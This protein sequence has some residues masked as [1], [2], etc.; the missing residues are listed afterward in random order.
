VRAL[1]DRLVAAQRPIRILD[2]IKWDDE[3]AGTFFRSGCRELPPVTRDYYSNRSL[4]FEPEDKLQELGGIERDIRKQL[5]E[6]DALAQILLRMSWEYRDAVRMLMHRGTK[7]FVDISRQLYGSASE[8]V[9]AVR[10]EQFGRLAA[11]LLHGSRKEFS[12][13]PEDTCDSQR[14]VDL[15]AARLTK[16]FRNEATVRVRLADGIASEAAAGS[17]YIKI[18]RGAQFTEQEVRLVE[19]HEGWVHFGTT[20]NGLA[21]PVCTFLSKGP[22]A[23]TVTQ[24]GLAVITEILSR[25]SHP[26]RIRRLVHRARGVAMAAAGADFLE[27]YRFFVEKGCDAHESY[28]CAARVFRGSLPAG[29]GPF[30]KD[31]SYSKGFGLIYD[32]TRMVSASKLISQLP[33]LFCG[34]TNIA[35]LAVLEQLVEQGIIVPPRFVPSVFTDPCA[36]STCIRRIKSLPVNQEPT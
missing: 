30:S 19:V 35:D 29:C 14:A 5:G 3:I 11:N 1:S 20:L 27:V 33:L 26:K 17:A 31:L 23:S 7:K 15:V 4:P 12:D 10:A 18:R 13:T 21:Q 8:N 36:L 24:E 32:Y 22:P 16:Y 9:G 25:A 2:A 34:K 28:H 6:F